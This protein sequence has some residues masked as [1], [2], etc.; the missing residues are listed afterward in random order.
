MS[1]RAELWAVYSPS[2]TQTAPPW[3]SELL[4]SFLVVFSGDGDVRT[5]VC[6]VEDPK[7]KLCRLV[8]EN[9][10]AQRKC[11]HV[12]RRHE[13]KVWMNDD[14]HEWRYRLTY[15]QRGW[16]NRVR[17]WCPEPHRAP[18]SWWLTAQICSRLI[19]CRSVHRSLFFWRRR[20]AEDERTWQRRPKT[21]C[22][23]RTRVRLPRGNRQKKKRLQKCFLPDVPKTGRT[24]GPQGWQQTGS[25]R[26]KGLMVQLASEAQRDLSLPA[27]WNTKTLLTHITVLQKQLCTE[28]AHAGVGATPDGR[29]QMRLSISRGRLLIRA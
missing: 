10:Q 11:S 27:G 7:Q 9:T 25:H 12:T 8:V 6:C 24:C 22:C 21:N 23:P 29:Y 16:R 2:Q 1:R 17:L 26:Q 28:R 20:S 14:I 3:R 19:L 4:V 13:P 15:W 18:P 5:E